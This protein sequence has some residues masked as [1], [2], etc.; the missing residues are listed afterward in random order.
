MP[1]AKYAKVKFYFDNGLWNEIMVRNA[2][3]KNWI[4]AEEAET[5]L[6]K[7]EVS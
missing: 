2:V 7:G 4:T 5:I 6:G 3:T 1:S